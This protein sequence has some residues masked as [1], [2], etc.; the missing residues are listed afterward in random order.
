MNDGDGDDNDTTATTT[1]SV[2]SQKTIS[3]LNMISKIDITYS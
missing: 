3:A 2:P 1:T